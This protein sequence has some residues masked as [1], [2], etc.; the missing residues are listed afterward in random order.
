VSEEIGFRAVVQLDF[1]GLG[2]A[3]IENL[4]GAEIAQTFIDLG[5]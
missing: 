4:L 2:I 5:A 1:F 3:E